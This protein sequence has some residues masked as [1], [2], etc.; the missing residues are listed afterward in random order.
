[1]DNTPVKKKAGSKKNVNYDLIEAGWR[2]GLLNPRQLALAYT[3]ETK[4]SVSHAAIIKHFTTRGVPRDLSAKIRARSEEMVTR[5][6]V[7]TKDTPTTKIPENTIIEE[8]AAMITAV[9][10]DHRK[11]ICRSRRITNTL[12][13]ELEKQSDPETLVMLEQLG[14]MLRREDDKGQ[15]KKNDLYNKIISLGERSKT[16]KTLAESL[17][18]LVDMER[19]A[20]SM[21]KETEKKD[22]PLTALLHAISTVN[23][24]GF[25]PQPIDPEKHKASTQS[26][27]KPVQRPDED[28]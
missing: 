3:E 15:D 10:L 25:A 11:D 8:G 5:A 1:M 23:S 18:I 19:T 16:M 12:L 2:A 28:D 22:D 4:Q 24:S 21:D 17:R 7:T 27:F 6:M 9:R 26:A 13:D 20:Y 14:E